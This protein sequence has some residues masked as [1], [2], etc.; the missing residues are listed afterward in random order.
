MS[1]SAN[2]PTPDDTQWV[3]AAVRTHGEALLRYATRLL[4]PAE[5]DL[6]RDVVQDVFVKLC[7]ANRAEVEDHLVEWLFTVCRNRSFDIL[8]KGARMT[9]LST[10]ENSGQLGGENPTTEQTIANLKNNGRTGTA[11]SSSDA[12]QAS[13]Q[14]ATEAV[15]QPETTSEVL[16]ALG[17]LP[18]NQQE[19][20]RLKFQAGLSYKEIAGITDLSIANVGFLIHTGIKS[21]RQRLGGLGADSTPSAPAVVPISGSS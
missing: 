5:G 19:V 16:G 14:A 4:K 8:R 20:I 2:S 9:V 10:F 13:A 18:A 7:Q 3:H 11:G 15:E 12:E 1:E 6:A 17:D 21:L